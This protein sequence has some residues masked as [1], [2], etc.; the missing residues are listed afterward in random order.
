LEDG[1]RG[2]DASAFFE[3]RADGTAGSLGG[4]EDNVDVLGGNDTGEVLVDYGETVGEVEGLAL[5]EQRL[6]LGPCFTL[7]G[8]L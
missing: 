6:N 4:D 7:S 2:V 5:G 1:E 8:V 3:E